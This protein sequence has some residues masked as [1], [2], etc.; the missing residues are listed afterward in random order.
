MDGIH[1]MGGMHGFGAVPAETGDAVFREEWEARVH[2]MVYVLLGVGIGNVD[3]FRH[4][5]ERI[6]PKDYLRVGYYGRWIRAAESL[7]VARGL[8]RAG[9]LQEALDGTR[10]PSA[11]VRATAGPPADGFFREVEAAPR[12]AVGAAVRVRNLHPQGHTRLPGYVRGK[13]G[14]VGRVHPACILPDT[15]AHGQGECPEYLFSVRFEGRELWGD[16]AEP[17]APVSVDLFDRY[18]EPV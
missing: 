14:V 6:A 17:G 13:C 4:A 3:A 9:E 11:T 7:L 2:G 5:I 8:L 12:F 10:A 18:L 16:T 15:N 1:D